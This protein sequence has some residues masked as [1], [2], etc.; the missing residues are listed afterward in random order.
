MSR[1]GY[2]KRVPLDLP[3]AAPR[4]QGPRRHADPRTRFRSRL[5]RGPNPHAVL[6]FLARPGSEQAP[7]PPAGAPTRAGKAPINILRAEQGEA[8][9]H[10]HAAAGG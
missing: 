4:R 3:G 10:H 2:V 1:M 9:H 6:F 7:R 5:H 8:H